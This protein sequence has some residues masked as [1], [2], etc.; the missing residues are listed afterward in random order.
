MKLKA[1]KVYNFS[2]LCVDSGG[3][4]F[5][6]TDHDQDAEHA[7]DEGVI[8]DPFPLLEQGLPATQTMR[9]IVMALATETEKKDFV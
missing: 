7:H 4:K 9:E 5:V 2:Y 1:N 8:A 6:F 3:G